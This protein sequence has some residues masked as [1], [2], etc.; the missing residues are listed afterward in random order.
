MRSAGWF[1][2]RRIDPSPYLQALRADGYPIFSAVEEFLAEF[3][4]LSFRVPE[5]FPNRREPFDFDAIDAARRCHIQDVLNGHQQTVGQPLCIV[6]TNR[7][8]NILISPSL[9]FYGSFDESLWFA[10]EGAVDMIEA[11]CSGRM[12]RAENPRWQS[13][14]PAAVTGRAAAVP[15][16]TRPDCS[17]PLPPA[18][19]PSAGSA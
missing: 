4:G 2:G 13:V 7:Q 18:T 10:G 12:Y 16:V 5:D 15:G 11:F 19:A 14:H 8:Y 6:G 9:K 3:G 1:P 17:P